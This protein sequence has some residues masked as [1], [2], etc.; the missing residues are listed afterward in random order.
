MPNGRCVSGCRLSIRIVCHR[1][2][3]CLRVYPGSRKSEGRQRGGKSYIII[4]AIWD[5]LQQYEKT[6]TI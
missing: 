1:G 2:E 5:H 3:K 4:L 6:L